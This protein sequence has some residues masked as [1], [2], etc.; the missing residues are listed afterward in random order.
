MQGTST[1]AVFLRHR[2]IGALLDSSQPP[3]SARHPK[4]M[5]SSSSRAGTCNRSGFKRSCWTAFHQLLR[6]QSLVSGLTIDPQRF[7]VHLRNGNEKP[8]GPDR[9]SAGERQLLAVSLLWGLARASGRPLPVVTDTPLGRLDASHRTHLVERY[10]PHASHQM[11]LLS[12]DEEID[13]AHYEKLKP[14]ISHSYRLS[15]QEDTAST[16]VSPGYFW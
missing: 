4:R 10:F 2:P 7:V 12:T 6:K 1:T 8:L 11:I 13:D 3:V 9:L 5:S 16:A 14:W 15:F